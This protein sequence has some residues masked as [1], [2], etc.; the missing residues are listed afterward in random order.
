[1][2]KLYLD[3]IQ[4]A[5]TSDARQKVVIDGEEAATLRN[6]IKSFVEESTSVLVGDSWD[7]LRTRLNACCD[8]L[9][10]RE[11]T[12]INLVTAIDTANQILETYMDGDTFLDDDEI[13]ALE[14]ALAEA[15]AQLEKLEEGTKVYN[16]KT[17]Q[18]DVTYD[19]AAI[20]ATK[21]QIAKLSKMIEKLKRLKPTDA[22]A[23]GALTACDLGSYQTAVNNLNNA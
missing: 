17:K 8:V 19:T 20:E 7:L 22:S 21:A 16:S 12:A 11:Q 9:T 23:Y 10:I 15:K 13:P 3:D 1:M 4:H 2:T 14:A 18:Y 6:A 5:K